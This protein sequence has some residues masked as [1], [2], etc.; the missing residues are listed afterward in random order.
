M[1]RRLAFEIVFCFPSRV[2]DQ[3]NGDQIVLRIDGEL[4]HVALDLFALPQRRTGQHIDS[5]KTRLAAEIARKQNEVGIW[6]RRDSRL[7][8]LSSL[9]TPDALTGL[10]VERIQAL[11]RSRENDAEIRRLIKANF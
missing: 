7:I 1:H 8:D 6:H 9:A 10:A 4:H 2:F 5:L 3:N 11:F